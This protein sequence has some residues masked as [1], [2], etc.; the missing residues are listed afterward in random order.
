MPKERM[1]GVETE[2]GF[3]AFDSAGN[4]YDRD[5]AVNALLEL[6]RASLPHLP[7]LASTG[8]FLVNGSRFYVDSGHHPE[9]ATPE[10][11]NPWDVVRYVL[12]GERILAELMDGLK[13]KNPRIGRAF[14]F[15]SNID[16]GGSGSTW[17][18]HESYLHSMDPKV[19]AT[20]IIPHLVSRIVYTGA[21]GFDN[22]SPGIQF[23]LSPRAAHLKQEI[24]VHSTHDRGIFHTKDEPLCGKGYHRLHV[25]CGESLSSQTAA[26][27]KVAATALV[28]ALAE[29]G[30][31]PGREVQL[32]SPLEAMQ[33]FAADP[34]LKATARTADGRSLSAIAIQRHYLSLAEAHRDTPF[35]P[36]WTEEACK[37]WR[38]ALDC[39][40]SN[41]QQAS[42]TF[43]WAIKL[44]LFE[45]HARRRGIAWKTI[46][47]WNQVVTGLPPALQKSNFSPGPFPLKSLLSTKGPAQEAAVEQ[48]RF[49]EKNGLS[50]EN[51]PA[52]IALEHE[53]FEVDTRFGQLG[54]GSISASLE[55]AGVLNQAVAGVDNIEHALGHPPA[56]GRGRLRGEWVSRLA[57]PGRG[58]CDWSVVWDVERGRVLDLS[59]P[60]AAESC[61]EEAGMPFPAIENAI[62]C[63][64][65][66]RPW[67]R[68]ARS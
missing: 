16:Y 52:F 31:S 15:K 53:L 25:L 48:Y 39:L 19:L 3:A 7:D 35:M 34:G 46:P 32:S 45:D 14:F 64:A 67:H 38:S 42:R 63:G 2:Y 18:C 66:G 22:R 62:A 12:A 23:L 41:P 56:S 57:P 51:L 59:D 58:R 33:A 24:S 1:F 37:R 21:G 28:V 68:R 5:E 54:G 6:A 44:T 43:D 10:C 50:W 55:A 13:A 27:L 47:V 20:E 61:W 26:W 8:M 29:G 30:C 36:P 4:P 65:N 49:L 11:T 17:G 40:E 60:F 9:M